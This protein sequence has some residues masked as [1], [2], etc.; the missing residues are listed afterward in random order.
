MKKYEDKVEQL[1]NTGSELL[2]KVSNFENRLTD[3]DIERTKASA[4]IMKQMINTLDVHIRLEKL[5]NDLVKPN[6]Q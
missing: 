4:A 3:R 1:I 5:E 2:E 6:K